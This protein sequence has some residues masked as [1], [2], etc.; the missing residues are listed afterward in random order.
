MWRSACAHEAIRRQSHWHILSCMML[1]GP[2]PFDAL[3]HPVLMHVLPS[4]A[5]LCSISN[6]ISTTALLKHAAPP[7]ACA[8]SQL[9]QLELRVCALQA[10]A[11]HI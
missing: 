11:Q 7:A 6:G 10:P 5:Q 9:W 1:P 3:I 2:G 8:A 4:R